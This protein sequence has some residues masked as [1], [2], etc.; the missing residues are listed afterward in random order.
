MARTKAK[1]AEVVEAPAKKGKKLA[2]EEAVSVETTDIVIKPNV[3]E[4]SFDTN[5]Q[6]V[7]KTLEEKIKK[8][9]KFKVTDS[10]FEEAKAVKK[11]FVSM[12]TAIE[13]S[14]KDALAM[15]IAPAESFLKSNFAEL[16]TLV[17]Q[18]EELLDNQL[19]VFEQERIDDLKAVYNEYMDKLQKEYK[20]PQKYLDMVVL[21]KSYFNKTAKEAEV[22]KSIKDQFDE[23]AKA[24]EDRDGNEQ[25]I[26]K[27]CGEDKRINPDT[28]IKQLDFGRTVGAICADVEN[29]KL[30]LKSIEDTVQPTLKLGKNN[31]EI[32]AALATNPK[33]GKMK[34]MAVELIF[35]SSLTD[36]ITE[37]FKENEIKVKKII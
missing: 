16:A 36:T 23:A 22:R 9:K 13:A 28:F 8:F 17:K 6:I 34:R 14:K 1:E 19:E 24:K 25:L 4:L 33:S 30:R 35:D 26:R 10:N 21:Q 20:L 18:G 29:E 3:K 37:F 2:P 31:V 32:Q 15:Y 12:R 11:Q 7:K 27:T 5:F